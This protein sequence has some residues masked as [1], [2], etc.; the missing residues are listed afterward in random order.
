MQCIDTADFFVC[1]RAITFVRGLKKNSTV[2]DILE[3]AGVNLRGTRAEGTEQILE[4]LN[5]DLEYF[6]VCYG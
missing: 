3:R 5:E 6:E 2:G 1:V 4:D